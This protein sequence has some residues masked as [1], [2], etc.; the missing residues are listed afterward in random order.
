[1]DVVIRTRRLTKRFGHRTARHGLDLDA[2]AGVILC[3][4]DVATAR[5]G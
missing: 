4:R 2:P 5:G 1:M 3:G